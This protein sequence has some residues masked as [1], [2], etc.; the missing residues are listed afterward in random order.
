MAANL[1]IQQLVDKPTRGDN[2]LDVL[3]TSHPGQLNRCKTIPP[4]GNSDH[5]IVLL[6]FSHGLQKPKQQKRKIYLWKKANIAM[7]NQHLKEKYNIFKNTDFE[8]VNSLWTN[9]KGLILDAIN[10]HVPTRNTLTKH[11]HPWMNSELRRLSNKKQRAYTLA[12]SSGKTRDIKKYKFLK[13]QLQKEA[14]QA[15]SN[16]MEDI[17][18]DDLQKNPKR[19]WSYVKS[20]KQD[21]SQIVTLKSKDGFLHSDTD[22][23]VSI[24]NQQFQ[25]VYT[26]EDTSTLPDLGTSPHPTMDNIVIHERGVYKLLKGLRPFKATGPDEVPTNIL[27]QAA[28]SLAPYLTRMF[29]LSLD[30]GKIPDE[31]RKV[32]DLKHHLHD[33]MAYDRRKN[34]DCCTDFCETLV[35][36]RAMERM[37]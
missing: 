30:E 4:L 1:N 5:D 34:S 22:T 29:Q 20:R 9:I 6:D 11:S 21:A 13:S 12:K 28:E 18:S 16:Y 26:K 32:F 31:W 14:R 17:V 27:K 3:F 24:L 25:S 15:H 37:K 33:D 23:K 36:S 10:Q 8:D 35:N 2:T 7:I 19:F